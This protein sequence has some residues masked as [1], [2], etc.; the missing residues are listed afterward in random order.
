MDFLDHTALDYFPPD[1][2][3]AEGNQVDESWVHH[4]VLLQLVLARVICLPSACAA[5]ALPARV[6]S[7][8]GWR[9]TGCHSPCP[10]R[11]TTPRSFL[12]GHPPTAPPALPPH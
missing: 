4:G 12:L 3:Y 1:S 8:R 11:P 5:P 7:A 6:R 10:Q 2:Y 9:P